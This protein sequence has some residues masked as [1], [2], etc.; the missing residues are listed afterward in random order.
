MRCLKCGGKTVVFNS[1]SN[2]FVRLRERQCKR[3]GYTFSTEEKPV[4][5]GGMSIPMYLNKIVR[6]MQEKGMQ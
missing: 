5:T 4:D 6:E 2:G 3:C 1:R